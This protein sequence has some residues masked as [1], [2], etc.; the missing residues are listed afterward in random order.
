MFIG[1]SRQFRGPMLLLMVVMVTASACGG[2][3]WRRGTPERSGFLG[4]YSELKHLEGYDAQ[5]LYINPDARWPSYDAVWIESVTLWSDT[6]TAKL[7]AEERQA[8]TDYLYKGLHDGISMSFQIVD[9][10]GPGVLRLRAALT[11]AKG[12]NVPL[13]TITTIVPQLRVASTLVGVSA[14]MATTVGDATVEAEISD[15]ITGE[16]LAAAVD[17]RAGKKAFDQLKKWSDFEVA[18]EFWGQRVRR[19]LRQQGVQQLPE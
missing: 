12:A 5:L 3:R 18:C 8:V 13:K 15:S 11:K 14:D 4:D 9:A 1:G 16:R 10:P 7:S 17:Q 19:F 2:V 6:E